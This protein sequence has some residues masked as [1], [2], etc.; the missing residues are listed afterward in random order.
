M[1][2]LKQQTEEKETAL[3]NFQN[4]EAA[5]VTEVKA[6][7]EEIAR[8][9]SLMAD[10]LG[11]EV[12]T[13]DAED[14]DELMPTLSAHDTNFLQT[15]EGALQDSKD[16]TRMFSGKRKSVAPPDQ[17]QEARIKAAVKDVRDRSRASLAELQKQALDGPTTHGG[18]QPS[19]AVLQALPAAQQELGDGVPMPTPPG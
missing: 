10:E 6:A 15:L 17:D 19:Q 16:T 9:Q 2:L 18:G 11:A 7:T 1:T 5:L 14:S 3:K 12:I 13:S 4:K 8:L